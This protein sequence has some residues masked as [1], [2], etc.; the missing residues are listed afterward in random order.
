MIGFV[1]RMNPVATLKP[2]VRYFQYGDAMTTARRPDFALKEGADLVIGADGTAIL[3]PYS[4]QTLLGDVGVSF[5]HV[6]RD[7]TIVRKALAGSVNLTPEADE[8]LLSEASRTR[9]MAKR[10]R[11]LPGRLEAIG[12][13]AV[14]LRKVL[15][16]HDVD[17]NLIL[18][19]NDHFSFDQEHV[20]VFFDAIECRYLRMT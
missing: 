11:L 1:S 7:M 3:S 13:D 8:A 18:D 4:F 6:Q 2:G 12:L 19:D 14:S 5:D 9:G 20:A 17:S 16:K 10:L 15:R